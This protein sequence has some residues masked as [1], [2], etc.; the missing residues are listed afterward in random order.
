MGRLKEMK[1]L[2]GMMVG[3][4]LLSASDDATNFL[5]AYKSKDA[6]KAC[7]FGRKLFHAGTKDE[8]ILIATG[9]VCAEI[10]YIDFLAVLQQRLHSSRLSREAAVYF[11]SLVLQKR[12]ISQF[13]FEDADLSE[14][15]LP[16]SDHLL[17]RVFE[18]IKNEEYIVIS[19]RPKRIQIGSKD[20]FLDLYTDKMIH[21]DRYKEQQKIQTH[22]YR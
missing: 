3:W 4:T 21:I 11:S 22:R 8:K 10:D 16:R 12:L 20:D 5:E 15:M 13:M 14:Y 1:W 9:Q 7:H 2:L 18:A 17:S 6:Q 19:L